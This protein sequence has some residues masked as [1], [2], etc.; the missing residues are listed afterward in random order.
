MSSRT[1]VQ[2]INK[3]EFDQY[4]DKILRLTVKKLE[5]PKEIDFQ[6][7]QDTLLPSLELRRVWWDWRKTLTLAFFSHGGDRPESG[8]GPFV[9]RK[10]EWY[11]LEILNGK[12][13]F[14]VVANGWHPSR[15]SAHVD[16]TATV[17]YLVRNTQEGHGTLDWINNPGNVGKTVQS[18]FQEHHSNPSNHSQSHSSSTSASLEKSRIN[19]RHAVLMGVG[20]SRTQARDGGRYF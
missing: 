2:Y 18:L 7:G 4:L 9:F 17:E 12:S 14:Q 6:D 5:I 8:K 3:V 20:V 13:L 10:L 1:S 15:Y 16:S 19:S 11:L